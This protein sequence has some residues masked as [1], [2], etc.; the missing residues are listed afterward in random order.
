MKKSPLLLTSCLLFTMATAQSKIQNVV[1]IFSDDQGY[2]D[3]SSFGSKKA[4]TP[5]IDQ[6]A[7]EGMK[8]TS[9]YVASSVCSPSRASLLTGRMPVRAGA[10]HVVFSSPAVYTGKGL[11]PQE[12]TI[13]ELL[14]QKNY[15]TGLIGKWH[16]GH[17]KAYLPTAQGFDY[18]YGLPYS[19]DMSIAPNMDIAE[20]IVL[21]E[22]YTLEQLHYDA[23]QIATNGLKAY[24][25]LKRK[26]PLMRGNQ[27][28]EYPANQSTLTERYTKEAVSFIKRNKQ[29]P[30]FLYFAHTF[31]HLPIFTGEK[32]KGSSKGGPFYDA[33]Q[34]I[35]WSVGEVMKALKE[36]GLDKNTL[37]IYTSDNGPNSKGS[38][39]PLRGSKFT[40][41][42][43]GLRV[44]GIIWAPTEI[45]PTVSDEIVSALDLFPTIA[46]YA[47]IELPKDRIY[48]GVDI[49]RF[50]S[51][52]Q[53]DSPRKEI[54]YYSANTSTVDGIR[55]GDW[56][57]IYKGFNPNQQQKIN[58]QELSEKLYNIK[59][60]AP[61]KENLINKYPEKVKA[62]KERMES[63]DIALKQDVES[64]YG[65]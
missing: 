36:Q 7:K 4:D 53:K 60:D 37:V 47:G 18:F 54:F 6:L 34:E 24:K 14:K 40:T 17:E 38:A 51:G 33:V 39:K 57:F 56:K 43:G 50:L 22:G 15:A 10:Q 12:I 42:E 23:N 65:K 35:D 58:G 59:L 3:L 62:L 26:V 1:V 19:N 20:D 32:F 21:N 31:P 41:Y 25:K 48:D 61:E 63:F 55:L 52:E 16:L 46:N 49:S 29:K 44:P 64:K 5:Y 13:A 27:V 8:L 9:F 28:I 30:F 11:P 2:E 45:E